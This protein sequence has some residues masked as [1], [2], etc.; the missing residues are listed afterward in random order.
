MGL[1]REIISTLSP[2]GRLKDKPPPSPLN[3]LNGDTMV[4]RGY[5]WTN[6][7]GTWT[8]NEDMD[9]D[10]RWYA[11]GRLLPGPASRSYRQSRSKPRSRS[12][13]R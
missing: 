12:R 6:V 2:F 8:P 9:A 7:R 3:A 4:K 10:D 11:R 13:S 5:R 1:P